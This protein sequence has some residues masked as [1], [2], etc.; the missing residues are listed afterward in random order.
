M[1]HQGSASTYAL[2][3]QT[4]RQAI[5]QYLDGD[6]L[7]VPAMEDA[8]NQ[9]RGVFVTLWE[10]QRK[11]R[12]CMGRT[13]G[14]TPSLTQE[15]AECAILAATRDPRFQPLTQ[16]TQLQ[17]LS[18]ELSLLMPLEPIVN[19]SALDPQRY[20]VVVSAG[21]RRGL[22]LPNVDGIDT[23]REQLHVACQKGKI[24]PDEPYALSRFEVLKISD[25][26]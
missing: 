6:S 11:L 16:A 17:E 25:E 5:Q 14:I 20:G 18:I 19:E 23:V 15:V 3:L 10:G 7:N 21:K 24:D 12:G 1:T 13:E 2:L 26:N 4:A 22:L 8:L 9:S